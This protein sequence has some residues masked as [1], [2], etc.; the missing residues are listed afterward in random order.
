MTRVAPVGYRARMTAAADADSASAPSRRIHQGEWPAVAVSFLYFFCVLAAYYMIRPVREQLSAAVGSTQLPWFY[1]ATFACMLLLAPV[2]GAVVSRWPRHI[3]VPLFNLAGIACL[4]AFVPF[5]ADPTL[6]PQRTLGIA[7]FV[8]VSVFNL[9]VVSLFWIFMTDIWDA[10]QAKRLFPIIAVAGTAGAVAGPTLT[11]GLVQVLGVAPLLL[12]SASLLGVAVGCVVWLGRWARAHAH[13]RPDQA[14]GE[15]VGGGMW[16]GI[17]QIFATPFMRNMAFL[18]LLADGIGTVNYALVTDYSHQA[19]VDEVMRTRFAA[20]VDLATNLLTVGTQLLL[21]R[22]ML[23]RH[24]AGVVLTVWAVAGIAMLLL[25]MLVPDAHA[26]LVAGMPAVALALI[27]TRGLAYGM[28]E[29][30]RHSLFAKAP[31]VMRYKGQNV[32]DTAVWRFGDLV[33]ASGMNLLRAGGATVATFA[34]ISAASA[35]VA[36]SIGWKLSK[37]TGER[38]TDSMRADR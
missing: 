1:G 32:V 28:A 21:T 34:A 25:V 13:V 15:A 23:P 3:V 29:P 16:D 27:V 22:W 6:L 20:N 14:G 36:G 4:L 30:A 7:F 37:L 5:F 2:F 10:E 17:K 19:F 12:V 31:R 9:F 18:L 11:R 8:W 26:P 33:I 38:L 35:L 24:G